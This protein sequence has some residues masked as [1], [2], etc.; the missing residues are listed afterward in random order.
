MK[1]IVIG[2]G[3]PILKDD[4]VGIHVARE[5][6]KIIKNK[7]IEIDEAYT[8]GMN[9]LD[10]ILGFDKAII[11]DSFIGEKEGEIRKLTINDISSSRSLNPHGLTLIESIEM[12]RRL[13]ETKIP[14]EI[15]FYVIL[16]K[17][18]PSEF[19]EELRTK[20]RAAI[21]KAVNMIL[22]EISEK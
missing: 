22:E 20:V 2:V 13:G 7:D 1:T 10:L 9:L 4:A 12:A 17:K 21:P 18:Y 11:A 3:N 15:M 16:L 8:G 14:E 19:G 5:L 6:K